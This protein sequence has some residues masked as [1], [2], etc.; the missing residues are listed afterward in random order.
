MLAPSSAKSSSETLAAYITGF[1]VNKFKLFT[2][3]CS[4]SVKSIVL[5][6]LLSAKVAAIAFNIS[7]SPASDLSDFKAL[8]V[9][10]ILLSNISISDNINSKFIVSISL[11]GSTEPST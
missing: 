7:N 10:T 6:D 5:T 3:S 4:S 2:N 9:L 1:E 11:S 8:V